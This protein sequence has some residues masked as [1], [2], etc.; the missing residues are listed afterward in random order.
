VSGD[1][2]V[3]DSSKA[4]TEATI[5]RRRT[6]VDVA[7]VHVVRDPRAVAY[8]WQRAAD[9][10]HTEPA[11]VANRAREWLTSTAASAAAA[12][13]FPADRRM[14]VRYETLVTDPASVIPAVAAMVGERPATLGFLGGNGDRASR[15]MIAGNALR[16]AATPVRIRPDMEWVL[17]LDPASRRLVT[18]MTG[19]FLLRY[20]YP[21]QP[22]AA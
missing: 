12:A 4:P 15:H 8:S 16:D 18:A 17:A 21:L 2:V 10:G 13:T 7:V 20:G 1:R 5:L 19:P 11:S 9:A 22:S 14:T 6:G 3:V